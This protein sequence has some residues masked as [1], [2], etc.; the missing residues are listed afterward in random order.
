[1]IYILFGKSGVGKSTLYKK[2][3]NDEE[4]D[5][6]PILTY[7]T[8]PPRQG[9]IDG[10]DYHFLTENEF[11]CLEEEGE[12]LESHSYTVANGDIWYYG[13]AKKDFAND[14]EKIIIADPHNIK[15]IINECRKHKYKVSSF[16]IEVGEFVRKERLSKRGDNDKEIRR[17]MK[18]DDKDFAPIEKY[19][20]HRIDTTRT[21]IDTTITKIKRIIERERTLNGI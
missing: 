18:A 3:I 21:S 6:T 13:I 20:H 12:L 10:I 2:L 19:A 8:R 11:H 4:L 1:M 5:L 7:T 16:L 9:E 14:K 17:R 15:A